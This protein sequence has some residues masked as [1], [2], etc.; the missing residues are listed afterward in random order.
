MSAKDEWL[1]RIKAVEKEFA[2]M[3]QAADRLMDHARDDPSLL[4]GDFGPSDIERASL[5]LEGTYTM[6]LYAEFEA[7]LREFWEVQRG[8][9]PPMK[10][11]IDAVSARRKIPDQHRT[12][13]H[14]IREFR[15]SLT[16]DRK[17]FQAPIRISR[18]R[19]HLCTFF[20]YLP[21]RWT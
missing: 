6:R 1:K 7:G 21:T 11:L 12:H 2:A 17:S 16:H 9:S 5:N 3:R 8:T 4:L 18:V 20:G 19:S 13:A 14:L 10:D 15:N